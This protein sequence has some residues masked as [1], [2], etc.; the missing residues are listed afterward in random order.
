MAH[1]LIVDDAEMDRVL[2]RAALEGAGHELLFARDGEAAL[3]A[4]QNND[5]DLVITDLA[6]PNMNGMLLIEQILE[7]TAE[8]VIIAVSGVNPEQLE[9]AAVLGATRT[10][11]KPYSPAELLQVVT[12]ALGP[13]LNSALDDLWG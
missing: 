13:D 1:I 6:M 9:R 10:M 7:H 2:A 5:I 4:Y 11:Q 12:E 8:A 3:Q